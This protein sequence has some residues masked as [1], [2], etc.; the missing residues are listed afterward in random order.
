MSYS[1][2]LEGKVQDHLHGIASYSA[3][4]TVYIAF[5]T[6]ATSDAGGGTEVTGGS[7]ARIAV[8]N[9]ATEWTRSANSVTNDNVLTS[10]EATADWGTVTNFAKFDALSGG[11]MLEHEAFDESRLIKDGDS[12]RLQAGSLE[13]TLD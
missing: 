5:F 13:F 6:D 2:Y 3:P 8:T 7:Y 4:A 10:A 1:D 12:L 11:N 9:D